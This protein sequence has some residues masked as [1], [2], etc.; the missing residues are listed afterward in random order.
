MARTALLAAA[1]VALL[2]VAPLPATV[3]DVAEHTPPAAWDPSFGIVA[4]E[5]SPDDGSLTFLQSVEAN[6]DVGV[7]AVH[8]PLKAV[9]MKSDDAVALSS[10]GVDQQTTVI[11][12]TATAPPSLVYAQDKYLPESK[13]GT[14]HQVRTHA[15]VLLRTCQLCSEVQLLTE[16]S[17]A[18][19]RPTCRMH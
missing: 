13:N 10:V 12:V 15:L 6:C 16:L 5:N 4:V 8:G 3:T 14:F 9:A 11:S 7:N 18:T 1:V 19:R 17:C 2:V